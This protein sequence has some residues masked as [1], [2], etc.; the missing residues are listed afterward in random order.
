MCFQSYKSEPFFAISHFWKLQTKFLQ[1]FTQKPLNTESL[2]IF[3][4]GSEE[5]K[6]TTI[7]QISG[8]IDF[9]SIETWAK[10]DMTL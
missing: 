3:D 10:F 7:L 8:N 4:H 1:H 6:C 9:F 5:A 2:V